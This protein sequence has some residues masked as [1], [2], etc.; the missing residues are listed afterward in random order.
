MA[1][2]FHVSLSQA[3]AFVVKA[4]TIRSGWTDSAVTT[5][6]FNMR[7]QLPAPIITDYGGSTYGANTTSAS[8]SHELGFNVAYGGASDPLLVRQDWV[9]CARIRIWRENWRRQ[10]VL[11]PSRP[12]SKPRWALM[13]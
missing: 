2:S 9:F 11:P 7:R 3:N 6:T 12:Q 8:D 10:T 4:V 1:D 5:A 13:H